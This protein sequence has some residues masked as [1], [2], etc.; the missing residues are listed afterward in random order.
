MRSLQVP[1]LQ[2]P[3]VLEYAT[4]LVKREKNKQT[5]FHDPDFSLTKWKSE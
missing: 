4:E 5:R 1:G 3:K 2:T